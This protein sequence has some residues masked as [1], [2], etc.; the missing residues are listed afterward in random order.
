MRITKRFTGYPFAHRQPN[1]KGHCRL[2]HGHNWDFELEF[3]ASQPDECGFV[4]DFGH[5][6][7]IKE[8]LAHW[9]DHTLVLNLSDPVQRKFCD[10]G[11]DLTSVILVPDCSAEGLAKFVFDNVGPEM[12]ERTQNR[13]MLLSVTVYE[14]PNN[15]ATYSGEVWKQKQ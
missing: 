12:A 6:G 3:F 8:A 13:V 7:W 1:H 5:M 14:N 2:L 11:P 4:Y 10:L 15:S 9:F